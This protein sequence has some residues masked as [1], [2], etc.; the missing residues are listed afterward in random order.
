MRYETV[1]NIS[2]EDGITNGSGCV[3][4][5]I[6]Y[7]QPTIPIPSVIWVLFDDERVGRQTS[8]CTNH[9]FSM[10]YPK[11]GHQFLLQSELSLPH[12]AMSQ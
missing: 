6:H 7:I 2:V 4:K 5:K 3:V 12:G 8:C 11:N 9:T 1:I 10:E